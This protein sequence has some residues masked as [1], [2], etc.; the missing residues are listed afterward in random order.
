VGEGEGEGEAR[1]VGV[2]G[3]D[4]NWLRETKVLF[5]HNTK[6]ASSK[7][8]SASKKRTAGEFSGR[9][10]FFFGGGGGRIGHMGVDFGLLV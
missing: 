6:S 1:R 5:D 2:G 9:A 3:G 4:D 7:A 10:T 8:H